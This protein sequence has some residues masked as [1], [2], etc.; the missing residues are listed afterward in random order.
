MNIV[1]KKDIQMASEHIAKILNPVSDWEVLIKM[2]VR[3]TSHLVRMAVTK[4]TGYG[5]VSV[6][7]SYISSTFSLC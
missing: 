5:E 3:Y 7:L 6:M 2:T 1:S 4:I